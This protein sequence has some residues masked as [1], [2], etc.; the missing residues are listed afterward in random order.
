MVNKK[1]IVIKFCLLITVI[2]LMFF[3]CGCWQTGELIEETAIVDSEEAEEVNAK[4]I[5]YKGNLHIAGEKQST[6]L[7]AN[8]SYNLSE[9]APV[10]NY[11]VA[12]GNGDLKIIQKENKEVSRLFNPMVNDWFLLF[13]RSIPIN[14]D[15][16]MGKGE[17]EL[18]L[19]NI[20]LNELTAALGTGDTKIDLTGNYSSNIN[21]HL[22]GGIGQATLLLPK[23][24]GVRILIDGGI[25]HISC[26][27]FNQIG[28][29]YYNSAFDFSK[30]KIFISIFSVLGKIKID[31]I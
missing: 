19:S 4:I 20:Y 8:L 17:N 27:G 28:N 12:N 29:L 1:N 24:V 15:I 5:I 9:W 6:L 31:L 7:V 14:L 21:V 13:N 22:V 11:Q 25:N 10:I 23:E 30:R 3:L 26:D 18:D 16:I 2:L